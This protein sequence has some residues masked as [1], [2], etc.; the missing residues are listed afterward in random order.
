[1]GNLSKT[2]AG[3]RREKMEEV[4]A[5]CEDSPEPGD[6][7]AA[8]GI[9]PDRPGWARRDGVRGAGSGSRY[10]EGGPLARAVPRGRRRLA[11]LDLILGLVGP[12]RQVLLNGLPYSAAV[13]PRRVG[14]S[15][16]DAA[17]GRHIR[18]W[19]VERRTS[20]RCG[21]RSGRSARRARSISASGP[22]GV[23][24]HR[25]IA[26]RSHATFLRRPLTWY[27]EM[28]Q[29]HKSTVSPKLRKKLRHKPTKKRIP[30]FSKIV[31]S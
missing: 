19:G 23:T 30:I 14:I 26:L 29:R 17:R 4:E 21:Q 6:G 24:T 20:H 22:G 13:V 11:R 12:G 27:A 5:S 28:R 10:S 8:S 3:L 1:M 2:H 7:E 25:G 16:R 15:A 9:E 31:E 18:Q